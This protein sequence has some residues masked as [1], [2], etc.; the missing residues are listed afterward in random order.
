MN[1]RFKLKR[2]FCFAEH[3]YLCIRCRLAK[4]LS[5]LL[6]FLF[7]CFDNIDG[8]IG[9]DGFAVCIKKR[10]TTTIDYSLY[11]A[12]NYK[13]FYV[14]SYNRSYFMLDPV[15]FHCEQEN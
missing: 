3:L 12:P 1:E 9:Y 11:L 4:S 13:Q 15:R 5:Y 14:A 8:A 10:S 2:A 6:K 7:R